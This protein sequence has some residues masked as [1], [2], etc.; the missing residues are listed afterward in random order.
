MDPGN[1]TSLS[2]IVRGAVNPEGYAWAIEPD[3]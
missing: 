2:A 1:I 3:K